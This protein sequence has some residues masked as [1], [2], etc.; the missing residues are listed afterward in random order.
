MTPTFMV[1][2]GSFAHPSAIRL[3]A[4]TIRATCGDETIIL[5]SDD[6]SETGFDIS[7]GTD[8]AH[9]ASL[10]AR[11]L[12]ICRDENLIYRDT[13][14]DRIGHAGGDLG[15]FFHGLTYAKKHGIDFVCKLSQRMLIDV[16]NWLLET[17]Q[18]LNR[19]DMHLATNV[20][21]YGDKPY[22]ALRTECMV[23][24][25]SAWATSEVL[26]EL[27]P[28]VLR[29]AAE[30]VIVGVW[31]KIANG[32]PFLEASFLGQDRLTRHPGIAWKDAMPKAETDADY[33]RIAEKHGITMG[34][35]FNTNHSLLIHGH[36]WG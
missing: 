2:I 20:C 27:H 18:T 14:Y 26:E 1:A 16:P 10:K 8:A 6:H 25:T 34:D 9:G 24:R 30:E 22:F 13:D 23:M 35:D 12:N 3:Q 36:R 11:L 33:A 5:V 29:M 19:Y 15:A 21:Y 28:R 31:H 32:K 7:K 4:R 17:C